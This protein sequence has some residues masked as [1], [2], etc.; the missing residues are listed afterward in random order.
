[1]VWKIRGKQA[2]MRNGKLN[3]GVLPWLG[4]KL[5]ENREKTIHLSI[6]EGRCQ[7]SEQN[8]NIDSFLKARWTFTSV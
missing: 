4:S 7:Q 1:M 3:D 8:I 2:E 6:I 5:C